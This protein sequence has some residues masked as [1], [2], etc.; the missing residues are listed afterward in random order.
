ML[1]KQAI[2]ARAT[3]KQAEEAIGHT[4]VATRLTSFLESFEKT[5]R[6]S[7]SARL[8]IVEQALL[9]LNMNYV[10]LPLKRAMH[11]VDPIQRL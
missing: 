6:L 7:R 4:A 9:L 2:G 10:H 1:D 5:R 8:R 11:A 3:L